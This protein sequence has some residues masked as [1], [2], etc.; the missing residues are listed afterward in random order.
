MILLLGQH[1]DRL[2]SQVTAEL[3]RTNVPEVLWVPPSTLVRDLVIDDTIAE[4]GTT[5]IRWTL[6]GKPLEVGA[7]TGVLN[8]IGDL[9]EQLFEHVHPDDRR[10]AREECCAYLHFALRQ[11][12]SVLN[13]P[14]MGGLSGCTQSLPYQ[15][16]LVA[17][18]KLGASVP[19]F[20]YGMVEDLPP[21]LHRTYNR[22]VA[23]HLYSYRYWNTDIRPVPSD[24]PQLV[25]AKPLGVPVVV[26][27]INGA[28]WI[29]E[30]NSRTAA[31]GITNAA[32]EVFE[33]LREHF[34]LRFAQALFFVDND[35]SVTFGSITPD[36]LV[37]VMVPHQ[38]EDFVHT[39]CG[40][41]QG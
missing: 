7:L 24:T 41:L 13:P 3:N 39:L 20:F 19:D 27:G 36:I 26:T 1:D 35:G 40:S 8:V 5:T 31:R 6:G 22:V 37:D 38:L 29:T 17:S 23:P 28:H 32:V 11:F 34:A 16:H 15:W 14:R 2:L 10:F 25:Y 9:D 21:S 33:H 12:P 4:D 18:S 30:L